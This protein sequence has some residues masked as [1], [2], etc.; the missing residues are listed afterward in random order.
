MGS[1]EGDKGVE[2]NEGNKGTV[3]AVYGIVFANFSGFFCIVDF[4]A[5]MFAKNSA[6][7]FTNICRNICSAKNIA[8]ICGNIHGAKNTAKN[9]GN[10]RI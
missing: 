8:S 7:I 3:Y 4:F 10:L 6:N 1:G 2:V 5:V 9:Y